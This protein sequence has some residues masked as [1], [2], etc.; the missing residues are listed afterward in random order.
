MVLKQFEVFII[1]GKTAVY[2]HSPMVGIELTAP[3]P[4]HSAVRRTNRCATAPFPKRMTW[5]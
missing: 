2:G 1:V 4:S 5:A 3:P